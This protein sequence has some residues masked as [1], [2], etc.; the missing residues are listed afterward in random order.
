MMK[1]PEIEAEVRIRAK[2]RFDVSVDESLAFL[3]D[4]TLTD[5]AALKVRRE[6]KPVSS[7][8]TVLLA[9]IDKVEAWKTISRWTAQVR[10]V[11]PEPETSDLY[12]ILLAEGFSSHNCSRIEADE[13]FCRKY[14]TS[15]LKE[16]PSLLDR[17]FLAPLSVSGIGS[18]IVDPV[19]AA[20]QSTQ[21]KHA[22]LT[23]TVQEHWFKTFLSEKTGKD[24]V[25]EIIE[26]AESGKGS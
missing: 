24:L 8:R 9:A 26:S 18:G 6:A 14:V 21:G 10:D 23:N 4:S 16:I 22:W 12:L 15:S 2:N 19:T 7:G 17:T 5:V 1:T 20:F 13:Q 11:L 3:A 25:P